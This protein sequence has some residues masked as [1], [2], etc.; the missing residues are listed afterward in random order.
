MVNIMVLN[1]NL[2]V[3]YNPGGK[4][5][6]NVLNVFKGGENEVRDGRRE[7]RCYSSVKLSKTLPGD[8]PPSIVFMMIKIYPTTVGIVVIANYEMI[9]TA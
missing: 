4:R 8:L 6:L 9:Y 1:F 3:F 5:L 2:K 7:N